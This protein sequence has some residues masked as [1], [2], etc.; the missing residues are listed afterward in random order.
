[1]LV[2]TASDMGM[3]LRERRRDLG[4]TQEQVA[5]LA[6]VGRPWLVAVEAG[7]QRAELDK[8]LRL[9]AVLKMSLDRSPAPP[10]GDKSV[11]LDALLTDR[12]PASRR[13]R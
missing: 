12:T 9:M 10:P 5:R 6:E 7:H 2:Q 11:D 4:L 1:M 13:R 3:A 8:V